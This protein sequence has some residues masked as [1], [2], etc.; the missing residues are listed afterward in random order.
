M[1][2]G[3]WIV[4]QTHIEEIP[5]IVI[6]DWNHSAVNRLCSSRIEPRQRECYLVATFAFRESRWRLCRVA[7][8]IFAYC[9]AQ[10]DTT[11]KSD[12]LFVN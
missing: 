9:R 6:P 5:I 10:P 8:N 4:Q 2:T 7:R 12:N 11:E 1:P 3:V